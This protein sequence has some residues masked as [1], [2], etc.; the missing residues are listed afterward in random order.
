MS[1][2]S[3]GKHDQPVKPSCLLITVFSLGG[4]TKYQIMDFDN[5]I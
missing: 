3:V 4:E 1:P 2:K 5:N